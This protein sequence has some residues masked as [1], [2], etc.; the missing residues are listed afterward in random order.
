MLSG[1]DWSQIALAFA[2]IPALGLIGVPLII[3]T[4]R[5]VYH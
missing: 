3:R 2:V 1:Y 4:C 5:S